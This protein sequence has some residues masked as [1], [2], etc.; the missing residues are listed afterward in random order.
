MRGSARLRNEGVEQAQEGILEAGGDCVEGADDEGMPGI[1][2][3]NVYPVCYQML[4]NHV[5][6]VV[7]HIPS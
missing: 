5:D 4:S 7:S 1:F 2:N 3:Y 6:N